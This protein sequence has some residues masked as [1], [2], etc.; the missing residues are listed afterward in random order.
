FVEFVD[1]SVLAQVG[2]PSMELPV[3]YALTHPERVSDSGVPQFDPVAASPLTFEPLDA[4][5]FPAFALGV[6]AGRQVGAAPSIFNAANE[7][8]VA[9]FLDGR[10]LFRDIGLAIGGALDVLGSMA[11]G[12]RDEL[13]AADA[14]ARRNV[15]ARFGC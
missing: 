14:A 5:R 7:A 8:A 9:L 2:V 6:A 1:G 12:S 3:L 15:Q 11:G 13:L 10:I 4:E